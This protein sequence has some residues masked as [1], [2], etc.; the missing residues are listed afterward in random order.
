M[1]KY[2]KKQKKAPGRNS[3]SN[4]F[5]L[6]I[7]S[8]VFLSAVIMVVSLWTYYCPSAAGRLAGHVS[9][10]LASMTAPADES[11]KESA[12]SP[13]D[14]LQQTD[15]PVPVVPYADI[16]QELGSISDLDPEASQQT[17]MIYSVMLGTAMGPLLYYNQGDVRWADYLY[18]G[19]DPMKKYGC[20][21]TA[22]AMVVNSFSPEGVSVT[23]VEIAAWAADHGYYA[24]QSGSYHS[25][26]PEALKAFGLETESVTQRTPDQVKTVL[27]SDNILVALMGKGRL[28]DNGHFILITKLLDNGNVSIADPNSLDNST[29]E[30]NLEQLLNELKKSYDSGGPLWAVHFPG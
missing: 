27:E 11:Y 22:V 23:P 15:S 28:T 25:L 2:K 19:Q 24:P 9:S 3:G 10:Y 14:S 8:G 1:K 12:D 21:P 16:S 5:Q 17:D 4:L 29:K 13:S 6:L 20:G 30:W 7:I 26:I 18:G